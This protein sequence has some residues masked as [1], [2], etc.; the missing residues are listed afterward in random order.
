MLEPQ[1][2]GR[3]TL[4]DSPAL[5]NFG[6][7]SFVC[8]LLVSLRGEKLAKGVATVAERRWVSE[9]LTVL[10]HALFKAITIAN[11]DSDPDKG[12]QV[13]VKFTEAQAEDAR[14]KEG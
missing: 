2:V 6:V 1:L 3:V 7:C 9:I 4:S 13:K 5:L 14:R 12:N 10:K 8:L 11:G